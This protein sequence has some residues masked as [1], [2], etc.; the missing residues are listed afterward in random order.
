MLVTSRPALLPLPRL[1]EALGESPEAE[2]VT[3]ISTPT[4]LFFEVEV[5]ISWADVKLIAPGAERVREKTAE[6]SGS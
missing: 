1:S 5:S 6:I 3:P 2:I 4:D